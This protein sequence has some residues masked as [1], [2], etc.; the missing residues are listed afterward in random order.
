MLVNLPVRRQNTCD[1]RRFW[2]TES[3]A[4]LVREIKRLGKAASSG[5]AR[6]AGGGFAPALLAPGA[7]PGLLPQETASPVPQLT[8]E[9]GQKDWRVGSNSLRVQRDMTQTDPMGAAV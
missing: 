7:P 5:T 3:L 6:R 8:L 9:L 1:S 2:L 4:H